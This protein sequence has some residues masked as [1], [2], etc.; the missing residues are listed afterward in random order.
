MLF[1]FW[2]DEMRGDEMRRDETRRDETRRDGLDFEKGVVWLCR[3]VVALCCV[4][5]CCVLIR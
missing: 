3:V 1:A 5:L 4:V 2:K